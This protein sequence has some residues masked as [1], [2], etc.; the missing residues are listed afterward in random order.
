MP[1]IRPSRGTHVTLLARAAWPCDAGAIVPAGGGRTIFVLPWLGRTLVGTTDNDYEGALDHVPPSDEDV[2]YLLDA[3]NAFFGTDAR[4]GRPDRR[5]RGRA[6]ADLDGRP[7]EVGRH[8]AQ[9]RAVRDELGAGHD[10]RRQAHHLAADG[11]AGGRPDRRARG[12]RGALPHARDP[13]RACPS[14]PASCRR[15]PGV[16]EDSRA[17][18]AARYGHAARDVLRLAAADAAA[19]ASGSP[20]P[21]RP[22]GRGGVRGRPRAGALARR[23]AAAPH[24]ARAARRARAVRRRTR[25]G[26]ARVARGAWPA[27]S[28]GTTRAWS[29]ELERW[30]EVAR[31]EGLVPRRAAAGGAHAARRCATASSSAAPA[32]DGHRQRDARLVL[33]RPGR[34]ATLDEHVERGPRAGRARAR[35]SSTSAA[36]PGA[37]TPRPCRSRRRPR[38]SC[39]WSSGSRRTALR[40][41][42][43][44]LARAGR[45]RGARGRRG[46]GQRR[47]RAERPRAWPT[48]APRPARRS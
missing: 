26:P 8:L 40:G 2:D 37:P 3:V 44:H 17:H 15:S 45:A 42:G 18:L 36:S 41:L 10:H 1:R 34:E 27:S 6:A 43:R 48:R 4:P 24:A 46:D 32:A 21:A 31:R 9:G 47:E 28:A 14:T 16:D 39:R 33:R 23:R 38:A 5:L 19:G 7:E 11:E 25:D 30:R 13:A 29:S 12:P 20:R 35:R 22:A